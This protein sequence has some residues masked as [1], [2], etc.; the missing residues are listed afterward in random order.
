MLWQQIA[1]LSLA[2]A[3]LA[4]TISETKLFA[5]LRTWVGL[6]STFFGKL[7]ACGFCLGHWTAL[8]LVLVYRA[9][10]LERWWP[11]DYFLSTLVIAW[12]SGLQWALMCWLLHQTGK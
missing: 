4:F 5:P 11:L 10:L 9:R 6:R 1:L 3:S 8:A 2:N 12:L 7:I